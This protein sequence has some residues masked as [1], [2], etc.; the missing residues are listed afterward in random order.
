MVLSPTGIAAYNIHGSTRHRTLCLIVEHCRT[1]NFKPL[2]GSKLSLPWLMWKD[3]II[4]E[5]R[6]VSYQLFLEIN[7]H[8]NELRKV[9][10]PNIHFGN[11]NTIATGDFYQLP[12]VHGSWIYDT[13]YKNDLTTQ[14][15]KSLFQFVELKHPVLQQNNKDFW[16]L[17]KSSM[18][19]EITHSG[20]L[21]HFNKGF[22]GFHVIPIWK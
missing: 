6:M 15:W 22:K 4:D 20:W 14:L 16:S 3:V 5:I 13:I 19:L 12:P 9:T 1:G 21:V 8:L 10:G 17:L 11:L 18:T 7:H 2:N